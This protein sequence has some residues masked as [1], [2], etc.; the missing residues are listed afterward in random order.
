LAFWQMGASHTARLIGIPVPKGSTETLRLLDVHNS[1]TDINASDRGLR[2]KLDAVQ[3]LSGEA[4]LEGSLVSDALAGCL[5][6]FMG[7]RSIRLFRSVGVRAVFYRVAAS[8]AGLAPRLQLDRLKTAQAFPQLALALNEGEK[9]RFVRV[10]SEVVIA[11]I[12]L[13]DGGHGLRVPSVG[14]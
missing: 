10:G 2:L 7:E 1:R 13:I 9:R 5:T 6:M 3:H 14:C 11:E 4:G 8:R 12:V